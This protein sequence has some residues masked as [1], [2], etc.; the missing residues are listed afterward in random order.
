MAYGIVHF[1]SSWAREQ[2]EASIAAVR[3]DRKSLS[4]IVLAVRGIGGEGH[5]G[6]RALWVRLICALIGESS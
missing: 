6:L 4:C 3:P 1:F 2:Y 5:G